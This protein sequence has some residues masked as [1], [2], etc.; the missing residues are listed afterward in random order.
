MNFSA[1]NSHP[2]K[3]SLMGHVKQ[4]QGLLEVQSST[5]GMPAAENKQAPQPSMED[6]M[7]LARQLHEEED[8]M[9]KDR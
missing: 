2:L 4:E 1:E 6:D 8:R 9:Q 3:Q 7:A 5:P